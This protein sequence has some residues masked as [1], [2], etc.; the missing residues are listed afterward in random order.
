MK[1]FFLLRMHVLASD[2][3]RTK[4]IERYGAPNNR[5]T[6]VTDP[7]GDFPKNRDQ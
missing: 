5:F 3:L 2:R 6:S 1:T 7:I 4:P